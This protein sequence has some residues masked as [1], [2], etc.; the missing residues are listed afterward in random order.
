MQPVAGMIWDTERDEVCEMH[1]IS[2][3]STSG[4]GRLPLGLLGCR[5]FGLEAQILR[6]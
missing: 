3:E 1:V 6:C 4:S 5:G 2:K